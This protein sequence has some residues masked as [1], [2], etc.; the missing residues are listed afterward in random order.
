MKSFSVYAEYFSS[1]IYLFVC[2]KKTYYFKQVEFCSLKT[3]AVCCTKNNDNLQNEAH[4]LNTIINIVKYNKR[5]F[6]TGVS[7]FKFVNYAFNID[8]KPDLDNKK[9]I[10]SRVNNY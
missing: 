3:D 10:S 7:N 9:T 8:H 2:F 1:F 5:A 6:K 4:I